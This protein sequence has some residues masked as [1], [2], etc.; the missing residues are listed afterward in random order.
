M[1]RN[2][3]YV[4]YR[5]ESEHFLLRQV[6]PEDA[7]GLLPCYSDPAA[8]ALMN[9]D[10]CNKGFLCPS[11]EDMQQ[12]IG[13]WLDEYRNRMYIRPVI[14]H[15]PT[16]QLLGTIEAFGGELGVLRLDLRADWE[17]PEVL[18]ELL[19]LAVEEFPQDLPMAGMVTKAIPAAKTRR[20]VLEALGFLGPEEFR[21]FK[22]YYR[23]PVRRLGIARCGL[24][25]CLC[26]ENAECPGCGNSGTWS[27]GPT[28]APCYADCENFGCCD[29]HGVSACW[30][31]PDFPCEKGMLSSLRIRTFTKFA[32]EYGPEKLLECLERN[33]WAGISYHHPGKLTGDYDLDTEQEIF[34]LLLNGK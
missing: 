28:S 9:D 12:Y 10:N 4:S 33:R 23:W 25:C 16:G 26:S 5:Y 3:P 21:G 11:L 19:K 32:K 15:K 1:P 27:C 6:A 13:F 22:D 24:A 31:C 2:D 14:I 17:K 34:D 18:A 20:E 8:V 29:S 7:P 30:Q